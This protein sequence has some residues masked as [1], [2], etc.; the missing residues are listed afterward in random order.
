MKD[1]ERIRLNTLV[2]V[3]REL[4]AYTS[5]LLIEQKYSTEWQLVTEE[6]AALK[7]LEKQLLS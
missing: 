2:G 5:A 4:A 7:Q 3:Y 6:I 1:S